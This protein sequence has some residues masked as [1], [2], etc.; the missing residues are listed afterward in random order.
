MKPLAWL[1]MGVMFVLFGSASAFG[2]EYR[3]LFNGRDLDGW[4]VEGARQY[5]DKDGKTQLNWTVV[6]GMLTCAGRGFGFLRYD[7][8]KFSDFSLHV[9]YRM[10][11]RANS[12]IGI[13][14]GPFDPTRS[15]ATRPSHAAYEVQLLD[16]AG[17]KPSKTSSGALY[18]YIAPILNATKPSPEWNE[19]D[20]DCEGPHIRVVMN[21]KPVLD[22]DQNMFEP[23]RGKPL[24][25]YICLQSHTYQ[26]VFRN[27]RIRERGK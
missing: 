11:P 16:D 18:G 24:A 2:Q 9:E 20:V 5:K 14:T 3:A 7:R 8:Q 25:G 13:R 27:V 19:I 4:V 23:T 26:V 15:R 12:G 6:D 22:V 10:A 1:A 21:G 17:K